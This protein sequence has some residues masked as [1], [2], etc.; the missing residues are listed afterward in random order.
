M[1]S[2]TETSRRYADL[3]M[4]IRPDKRYGKVFDVLIEFKFIPLKK[5]KMGG[6]AANITGEVAKALSEDDLYHL[7]EIKAAFLEGETQAVQYGNTL[8]AK[9]GNLRLKKFVVVSL[10]FERVCFKIVS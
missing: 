7:P 6:Q 10:G 4:I 3:T 8:E 1:D 5:V 2:E 9:Y